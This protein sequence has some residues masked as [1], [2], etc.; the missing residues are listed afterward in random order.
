MKKILLLALALSV[1]VARP[2]FAQFVT[3]GD[4]S[5]GFCEG[6]E[7]NPAVVSLVMD[8]GEARVDNLVPDVADPNFYIGFGSV[9]YVRFGVAVHEVNAK[10]D[11]H[12]VPSPCGDCL[13]NRFPATIDVHSAGGAWILSASKVRFDQ[14]TPDPTA[15]YAACYVGNLPAS[16]LAR[17]KRAYR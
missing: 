14:S 16:L 5:V 10:F 1:V 2:S 8:G 3:E 7:S 11:V 12:F 6:C 17:I 4:A 15:K 13:V 9:D